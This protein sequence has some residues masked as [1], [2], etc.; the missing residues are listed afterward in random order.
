M[1]RSRKRSQFEGQLQALSRIASKVVNTATE[2][3]E[4]AVEEDAFII[5]VW[6]GRNMEFSVNRSVARAHL[7]DMAV[8]SQLRL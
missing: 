4:P 7:L 8:E 6:A 5:Q 2:L 3:N 1:D